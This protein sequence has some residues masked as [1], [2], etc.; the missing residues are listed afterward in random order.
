MNIIDEKVINNKV[1]F[2][3][4]LIKYF[5]NI[6]IKVKPKA[7]FTSNFYGIEFSLIA[8]CKKLEIPTID[9]QHGS[10]S[11]IHYA[12]GNWEYI[13]KNGFKLLPDIFLGLG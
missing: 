12:Y 9:I 6:L 7:V 3:R 10:Q 8:A 5:E 2:I 13:P 11:S 4:I 1:L